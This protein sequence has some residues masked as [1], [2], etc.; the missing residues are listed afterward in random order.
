MV[1]E[2]AWQVASPGEKPPLGMLRLGE[3][4]KPK[5]VVHLH[6]DGCLYLEF[7]RPAR[8]LPKGLVLHTIMG[9]TVG[10]KRSIVA[11]GASVEYRGRKQPSVLHLGKGQG[12]GGLQGTCP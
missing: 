11:P 4:A 5:G 1:E 6:S 2:S 9:G 8:T 10:Q 7:A 3:L 12:P